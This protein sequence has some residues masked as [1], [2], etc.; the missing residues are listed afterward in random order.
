MMP[1][2]MA[3]KDKLL[4]IINIVGGRNV[5]QRLSA[6]GLYPGSVIKMITNDF[7]GPLIVEVNNSKIA[8][9]RGMAQKILVNEI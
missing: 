2:S 6:L 9:G 8:I 3:N 1:L 4:K 7:G 5:K